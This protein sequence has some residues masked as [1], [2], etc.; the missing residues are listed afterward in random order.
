RDFRRKALARGADRPRVSLDQPAQDGSQS[1]GLH[2]CLDDSTAASLEERV[3]VRDLLEKLLERIEA[4]SP[5]PD[6]YGKVFRGLLE[7][8]SVPEI[9]KETGK[10]RTQID[11][12]IKA[13]RG[14]AKCLRGDK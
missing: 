12:I 9:A 13:I 5:D 7:G 10:T 3:D 8:K 4:G 14:I 6:L 11:T 2:G 1:G